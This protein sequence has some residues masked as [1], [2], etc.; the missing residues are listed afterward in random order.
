MFDGNTDLKLPASL[1]S[2]ETHFD[3]ECVFEC[4]VTKAHQGTSSPHL[5]LSKDFVVMEKMEVWGSV[6]ERNPTKCFLFGNQ[7]DV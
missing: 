4:W 3:I 7:L 1:A 5:C 2:S 6:G